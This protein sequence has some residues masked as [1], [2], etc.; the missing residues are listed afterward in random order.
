MGTDGSSLEVKGP[1]RE[2]ENTPPS[3]AEAMNAQSC[4]T[5]FHASLSHGA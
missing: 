5:L 1:E 2:G 3:T 4:I